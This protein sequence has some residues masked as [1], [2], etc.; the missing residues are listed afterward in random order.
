MYM[1][2][3]GSFIIGAGRYAIP[4]HDLSLAG[5]YEAFAHIWV[6][7]LITLGFVKTPTVDVRVLSWVS[8]GVITALET[9]KFFTR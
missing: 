1:I 3:I 2:V 4:G 9:F 7:V 6:G 8:L 5:T